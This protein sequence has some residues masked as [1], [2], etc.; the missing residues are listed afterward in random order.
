[1]EFQHGIIHRIGL[2]CTVRAV[3][4]IHAAHCVVLILLKFIII[5]SPSFNVPY[6]KLFITSIFQQPDNV[7][8][9]LL[10][11]AYRILVG[12]YLEETLL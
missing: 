3:L 2:R 12:K 10:Q 6:L 4:A 5:K 7:S 8:R 1:M 9:N 11:L